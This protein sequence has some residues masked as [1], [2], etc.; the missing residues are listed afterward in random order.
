M[1]NGHRLGD[2]YGRDSE[3]AETDVGPLKRFL[4]L[5]PDVSTLHSIIGVLG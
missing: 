5:L 1:N 2:V 3:D 4:K